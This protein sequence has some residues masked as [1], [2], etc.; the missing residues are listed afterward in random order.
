MGIDLW[1]KT[2]F[3]LQSPPILKVKVLNLKSIKVTCFGAKKSG[4]PV[5]KDQEFQF[6]IFKQLSV[7]ILEL[8]VQNLGQTYSSSIW[9]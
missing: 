7:I 1:L 2:R 4:F 3:V 5:H 9:F 6:K 8:K